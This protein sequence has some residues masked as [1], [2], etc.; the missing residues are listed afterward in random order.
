MEALEAYRVDPLH[1]AYVDSVIKS[2][3]TD[4]KALDFEI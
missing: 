2:F 4:R 1:V 3:T